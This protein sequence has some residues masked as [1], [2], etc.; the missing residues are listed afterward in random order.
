MM[1][2]EAEQSISLRVTP[3]KGALSWGM[4]TILGLRVDLGA[5]IFKN[6]LREASFGGHKKPSDRET[7]VL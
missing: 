5:F 6:S 7:K 3:F 1:W 4:S 2:F